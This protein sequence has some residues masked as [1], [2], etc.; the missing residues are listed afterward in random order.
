MNDS[1]L[2]T[3]RGRPV[4]EEARLERMQKILAGA[5][6]CFVRSGFH[7]SSIAEIS[8]AAG[9][10]T[11][12][13]YQYY[14]NKDTLIL[15]LIEEDLEVDLQLIGRIGRTNFSS[16][17]IQQ[18][19]EPFIYSESGRA[20]A[21]LRA[22]I[23]S[24][25]A[26]NPTVMAMVASND[27]KSIA[28]IARA[29]EQAKTNGLVG[30]SVDSDTVAEQMGLMFEAILRQILIAPDR[31]RHIFAHYLAHIDAVLSPSERKP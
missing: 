20:I 18:I 12:N 8:A 30:K 15:A 5:R 31:S 27:A 23:I 1:H 22:E 14:P 24:E 26:R 6:A 7:A 9:V 19:L 21:A 4:N 10:S 25:A 17:A 2:S 29:I 28:A 13:I 3:A 11:A 16:R